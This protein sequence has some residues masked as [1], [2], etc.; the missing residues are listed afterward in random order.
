VTL[1]I[2][3]IGCA[4]LV[5]SSP[6][7]AQNMPLSVFMPKVEKLQSSGMM[8]MFSSEVKVVTSEVKAGFKDYR[9]DLKLE[10]STGHPSSCPPE[11]VP[12]DSNELL[13]SFATVPREQR[14]N[15]T[16]KQAVG[17]YMA[18]HYPCKH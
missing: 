6:V 10:T 5:A 9:A 2:V 15:T 18:Q 16:V 3:L 11:K 14:A 1:K 8:A 7:V 4:T 12:V 17:R 13:K